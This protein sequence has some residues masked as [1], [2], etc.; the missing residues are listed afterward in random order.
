MVKEKTFMKF[1]LLSTYNVKWRVAEWEE[2][3]FG[4]GKTWV[5]ILM[6]L[7]HLCKVI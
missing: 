1:S 5:W 7:C 2:H 3:S 6:W 4:I